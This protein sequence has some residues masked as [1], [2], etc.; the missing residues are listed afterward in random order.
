[1]TYDYYTC[2]ACGHDVDY[3]D[4]VYKLDDRWVCA[5]CFEDHVVDDLGELAERL[6]IEVESASEFIKLDDYPL[7]MER[8]EEQ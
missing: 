8:W 7:E 3:R 2:P 1:M 4:E 5:D 6:G